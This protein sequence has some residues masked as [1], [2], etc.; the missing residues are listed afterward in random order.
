MK[1]FGSEKILQLAVSTHDS[2]FNRILVKSLSKELLH[3]C[4]EAS[5]AASRTSFEV[6]SPDA[7]PMAEDVKATRGKLSFLQRLARL[8]IN[9][10]VEQTY[11]N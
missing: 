1:V 3:S 11:Y 6:T 5:R 2:T 8:K 10:K 7:L 4:N 9:L